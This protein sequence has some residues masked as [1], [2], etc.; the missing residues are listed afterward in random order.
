MVQEGIQA[1]RCCLCWEGVC[2]APKWHAV[3]DRGERTAMRTQS[4]AMAGMYQRSLR[5]SSQAAQG[6]AGEGGEFMVLRCPSGVAREKG[7][8]S[9]GGDVIMQ[10]RAGKANCVLSEA[11]CSLRGGC[12]WQPGVGV[13]K[14]EGWWGG[15]G[16]SCPLAVAAA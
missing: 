6:V 3:L 8:G 14:G 11:V 7:R 15:Q 16:R 10:H 9:R 4:S 5:K 13:G 2:V 1:M 12:M